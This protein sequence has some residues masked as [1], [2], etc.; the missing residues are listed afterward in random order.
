MA[1][2]KITVS[3]IVILKNIINL[4]IILANQYSILRQTI[5]IY[6]ILG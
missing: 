3:E 1:K 5:K 6:Q 2:N 4:T